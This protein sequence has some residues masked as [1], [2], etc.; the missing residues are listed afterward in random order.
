MSRYS[1][2]L[3]LCAL[4]AGSAAA[5]EDPFQGIGR[6]ATPDEVRAWDI[7]VRADFL[8]LPAGSASVAEGKQIFAEKC[9]AC[10]GAEGE[11]NAMF[12][13]LIGGTDAQDVEVGR[14]QA[15][16][17]GPSRERTV[18][19]KTATLSSL[20]DYI[21][22][23]MPWTEPKS[24]QPDEV[25][26]VLAYLLNLAQIVPADFVLNQANMAEVQALLPNRNGMTNDHGLWPGAPASQGG[27]GNGGTPD[28]QAEACMQD[29]S[30]E[31]KL[32]PPVPPPMRQAQGNP[33]EQ[34][35]SFGAVRGTPL[36]TN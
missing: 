30:E 9:A 6:A 7:D 4:L 11:S 22:R 18:F 33:A 19:M 23:A 36:S 2:A 13:P 34:N 20:F 8:G 12:T 15:L 24:L 10:H 27:M 16:S 1:E 32:S 3:L 25:Y 28:V 5:A 14:V 21:Q 26:G 35:R 17:A 29:C 31:I